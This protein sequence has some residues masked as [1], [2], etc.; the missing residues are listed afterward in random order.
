MSEEKEE[1][2]KELEERLYPL[3]EVELKLRM[4]KNAEQQQELSLDEISLILN[5]P[6][7][8]LARTRESSPGELSTPEYWL[9]WYKKTLAATE[10]A[11]RANRNF[12]GAEPAGGKTGWVG[13]VSLT[14][15]D[16]RDVGGRDVIGDELLQ[17]G[18]DPVPVTDEV[19]ESVVRG[20]I[21]ICMKST[22]TAGST[23]KAD[24]DEK[25]SA[26]TTRVEALPAQ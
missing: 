7:E 21:L 3:D 4:E 14:A 15:S 12:Q 6:V 9:S 10:E 16:G 11:R 5:I 13:A 8:T 23:P 22:G 25:D 17:A 24:S 26:E 20:N 1:Y 19:D 2:E 18:C